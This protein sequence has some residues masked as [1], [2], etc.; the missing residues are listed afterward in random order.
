MRYFKV[1]KWSSAQVFF[2]CLNVSSKLWKF[3]HDKWELY[4]IDKDFSECHDLADR[5]PEKVKEM[6]DLWWREAEKYQ[7]LPLD[8]R[9]NERFYID[10][11]QR[12]KDRKTFKPGIQV[13]KNR[14]APRY[15][16]AVYQWGK[17]R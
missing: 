15:R 3:D 17:G 6:V 12:E 10:K 2:K 14:R 7:V 16:H 1:A 9:T 13:R 4:H 8:D 5:Y 11:P